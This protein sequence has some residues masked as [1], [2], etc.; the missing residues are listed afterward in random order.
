MSDSNLTI[1][2]QEVL[3][4]HTQNNQ[5]GKLAIIPTKPL[6][7]QRDLS[8]AYSPGVAIPCL[9]ISANPSLIYNYT[10]KGNLVAV[11]SNGTAVLGLGNIGPLAAKPVM[12][13]KAVLFKRFADIDAIDIEVSTED[14]EEFINAI[15]LIGAGFGAINLEDIKAPECFYIEKRLN[16]LMDIP[17]FHDDQHGTAIIVGAALINA[18]EITGRSLKNIKV[19]VNGPGAA[20]IACINFIKSLG[21]EDITVCDQNGILYKGRQVG[22]NEIKERYAINTKARTLSEA[23]NGADLFIGLSVGNVLSPQMIMGMQK[24]P[25]IF[26]M[27]NPDPEIKPE[28]A[29]QVRP[30]V[31]IA[32]GRSDYANQI[33]N[34]MAFPGVLRGALDVNARE[35]NEAM[36]IAA[37]EELANLPKKPNLESGEEV[38]KAYSG[39]KMQYGPEYIIPTPFDPRIVPSV[40]FAVSKAA[41]KTQVARKKVEN[42]ETYKYELKSRLSTTSN[43]FNILGEYLRN[44]KKR[45]IFSE[46]EEEKIIKAALQWREEGYGIPVL[47]GKEDRILETMAE[48]GIKDLSGIEIINAAIST[49]NDEYIDYAYNKLQRKGYLYRSCVR[50]V[51]TDRNVFAACMLACG[52][53]DALVTGLTRGYFSSLSGIVDIIGKQDTMFGLS[54]IVRGQKTVFIADTAINKNPSAEQLAQ[55]AIES[56]KKVIQ[57]GHKPVVAFISHSSFS[58]EGHASKVKEA[59]QI[60]KSYNL[61]FAYDGEMSIDVALNKDLLHLYPFTSLNSE[62]NVLIMPSIESAHTSCKL[63]QELGGS[64]VVGPILVGLKKSVQVVGMTSTISEILNLA[65]LAAVESSNN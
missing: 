5:P 9:E 16:E 35:I 25:I 59:M 6:L 51:K 17:V 33:N 1:T 53:G 58:G 43:I 61:N 39:R 41:I 38:A 3:D 23:L 26:A 62:A 11:I 40:A 7:T 34:V 57:M 29:R 36:K 60:L 65:I 15:K 52:D 45:I 42:L 48:I 50:E 37:A 19:V 24:N 49:K 47:V 12:E 13:G 10:A 28:L 46:G 2:K 54:I 22:M 63:V 27:A 56:S 31:I 30:D 4:F 44:N 14:P 20:G 18:A 32:T 55:I 64:H 21:V 8:L